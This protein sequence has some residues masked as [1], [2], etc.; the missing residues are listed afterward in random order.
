MDEESSWIAEASDAETSRVRIPANAMT[1]VKRI[2]LRR[3]RKMREKLNSNDER[4]RA[5]Q[6]SEL[7]TVSRLDRRPKPRSKSTEADTR[8]FPSEEGDRGHFYMLLLR[9]LGVECPLAEHFSNLAT[10]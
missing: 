5:W 3:K 10:S 8:R 4:A 1:A 6:L 9:E 7:G 2:H